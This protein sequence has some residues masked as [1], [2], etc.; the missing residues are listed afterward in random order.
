MNHR[1]KTPDQI[2][3]ERIDALTDEAETPVE[4][5]PPR[6]ERCPN[7]NDDWH[8][9]PLRRDLVLLR[10][11][12]CGCADCDEDLDAYDYAT[13]TSAIVCPGSTVE[14]PVEPLQVRLERAGFNLVLGIL[15][16]HLLPLPE[17]TPP[18]P[19]PVPPPKSTTAIE[20]PHSHMYRA[21][22]HAYRLATSW[23]G[24]DHVV[25]LHQPDD[26]GT[27]A[28]T[29]LFR[30]HPPGTPQPRLG[31]TF[32]LGPLMLSVL[33]DGTDAEGYRAALDPNG[34]V[35]EIDDQMQPR[36]RA[37]G[38]IDP[39]DMVARVTGQTVTD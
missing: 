32:L 35:I 26:D 10:Q 36:Y 17:E 29:V 7:C 27:G 34:V 38:H 2:L 15:E 18:D 4:P 25:V 30:Y 22:V 9:L 14:G 1:D 5:Q 31:G 23:R 24:A 33:D 37:A 20:F 19:E 11:N 39:A 3:T 21:G 8:A 13:D 12:Y 28:Q 6:P 16:I